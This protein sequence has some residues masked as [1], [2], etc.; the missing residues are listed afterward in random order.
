MVVTE[1]SEGWLNLALKMA[2]GT[3]MPFLLPTLFTFSFLKDL[4]Y[5]GFFLHV[6]L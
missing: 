5:A 1:I 2:S 3:A 6:C 4:L